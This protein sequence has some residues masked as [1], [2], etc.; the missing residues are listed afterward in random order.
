MVTESIVDQWAQGWCTDVTV[1]N[2]QDTTVTWVVSLTI[3]G[4]LQTVWG[5]VAEQVGTE[6]RFRGEFWNAQLA[7]GAETVFGYC[8]GR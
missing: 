7:P 1:K 3:A 5:A 8:A 4:T 2:T 6:T